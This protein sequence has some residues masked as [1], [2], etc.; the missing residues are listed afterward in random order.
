MEIF[1]RV[2]G[3]DRLEQIMEFEIKSVLSHRPS[4]QN[5]AASPCIE[6]DSFL[7]KVCELWNEAKTVE[8]GGSR[9][10]TREDMF[11]RADDANGVS[12]DVASMFLERWSALGSGQRSF[13]RPDE[14]AEAKAQLTI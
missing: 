9:V 11:L 5:A 2:M 13:A 10:R 1:K 6:Q 12:G 8:E 4:R 7:L 14:K 3:D